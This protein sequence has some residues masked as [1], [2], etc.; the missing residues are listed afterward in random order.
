[1]KKIILLFISVF[2]FASLVA[3]ATLQM[4]DG[5]LIRGK[6]LGGTAD[7]VNFLIDGKVQTYAVS[8]ILLVDFNASSPGRGT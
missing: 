1:M 8:D 3:A 6:Y 2:A 5:R 4:K 7:S